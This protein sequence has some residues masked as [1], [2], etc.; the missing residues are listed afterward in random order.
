MKKL[1]IILSILGLTG[2]A[3]AQRDIGLYSMHNTFQRKYLNPAYQPNSKMHWGLPL[4]SSFS[5]SAYNTGFNVGQLFTLNGESEDLNSAE[6]VS[7]MK[8]LNTLG[9][10][11]NVDLLSIGFSTG[12][13]FASLSVR[14]RIDFQFNYSSDFMR[15]L[16]EGNGG[17]LI[18]KRINADGLGIDL[19]VYTEMGFGYSHMV[20]D[21]L[22]VGATA[23]YLLGQLNVNT[24][25][26][27]LG[28]T[29]DAETYAIKMDGA[30]DIRTSGIAF[31]NFDK[32][33]SVIEAT[34]SDITGSSGFGVDLGATYKLT[35]RITLG[36]SIIDLGSIKWAEDRSFVY[37]T[38]QFE[39]EYSGV[40]YFDFVSNDDDN[41]F[42]TE[43]LDSLESTLTPDK[44]QKSYRSPLPTRL[45]LSGSYKLTPRSEAGVVLLNNVQQE[46]AKFSAS[47]YYAV[48]LKDWVSATVN[49][50]YLNRSISNVGAGLM[51]RLGSVQIYAMADNLLGV[52]SPESVQNVHARAGINLIFGKRRIAEEA[53][54][55]L[56]KDKEERKLL[57]QQE[58]EAKKKLKEQEKSQ[59]EDDDS[60]LEYVTPDEL[61]KRETE[62]KKSKEEKK[63]KDAKPEKVKEKKEK[64]PKAPKAKK[65]KAKKKKKNDEAD[66]DNW[67]EKPK[68][69]SP[70]PE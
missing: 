45:M 52:V 41:D 50:S 57:K 30:L 13:G 34:A 29:T 7:K 10:N 22:T 40:D 21:K 15:L 20:N 12:K 51:F 55:Q 27:E 56:K 19:S 61:K 11:V 16:T 49:A 2:S 6:I 46:T 37:Q 47:A 58:R 9:V 69:E 3:F 32:I 17:D 60:G 24:V 28:I 66:F 63:A 31:D 14:E 33:D 65:E 68:E 1:L 26:T 43:L 38:N 4:I 62:E 53:E 59:D 48:A 42:F 64:A 39:F 18:G 54:E 67:N 23:K 8:E 70:Q 36:A 5:A 35:D 25:K 44:T